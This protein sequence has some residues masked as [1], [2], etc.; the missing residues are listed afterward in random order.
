MVLAAILSSITDAVISYAVGKEADQI[1][2][3]IRDILGRDPTKRAFQAALNEAFINLDKQHPQ[4]V[5]SCFDANFFAH[6]GAPI[7]AQFLTMNGHPRPDELA[8]RWA[9]ALNIRDQERRTHYISD[10]EPIAADFL[11]DMAQ[12]LKKQEALRDL[13]ESRALDQMA[14][15][16]QA[17]RQHLDAEQATF[18]TQQ[19]YLHWLIDRN[20]YLDPRGTWQTQRQVQLKLDTIYISLQAQASEAF[21]PVDHHP[22]FEEEFAVLEM[23]A[24][25]GKL[26]AEEREERYDGL[27]KRLESR[28]TKNETRE[29]LELAEVVRRSSCV[30][31]LGDPGS[32]KTTLLRY[33]ALQHALA[34]RDGRKEATQ[35][36]GQARFPLLIR[37][38]EYAE[39]GIWKQQSL[40][41]FF[42]TCYR[43]HDC[44]KRG[45]ADLLL[46]RLEQG[47][48]LVLLDGLDEIVNAD[49]RSGVVRQIEDFVRRYNHHDNRFVITSR[50]AG[51]TSA[52]LSGPF[53]HYTV[54]DMDDPQIQHFLE[55][56]CQAVEDAQTPEMSHQE[57]MRIAQRER[58][59]IMQAIKNPGVHRLAVNPLLLRILALI[60]RTGAKLP[61]KRIELYKL[62]TDTLARTWRPA[63]GVSETQLYQASELLKEEYLTRLLS[64]LAYWLHT[65]KPTGIATEREMYDVLGRAWARMNDV[66]WD[67]DNPHPHIQAEIRKF[68]AAVH[69]HTGL[70]VERAPKRYGFLHL[71]FEEYYV[72]R[73]L[74]AS[75][76]K[77]AKLIREHLHQSRWEEPILLALGFVGLDYPEEASKLVEGAILAQGEVAEEHNFTP[78]PHEDLLG[79]D[80]LFA[81]RC[82]GD[83]IPV[84]PRLMKQL[85]IRLVDDYLTATGPA[86]FSRYNDTVVEK[87]SQLIGS[88]SANIFTQYV[89]SRLQDTQMKVKS[90]GRATHMLG[91]IGATSPEVIET[92]VTVL[93]DNQVEAI[94][95]GNAAL[96]LGRVG[97][98][99]LEAVTVLVAVLQNKQIEENVRRNT[100]SALG[101][102]EM[103]YPEVITA[104]VTVLQD[105]QV[106]VSVR[107]TV[108]SA[109]GQVGM[110]LALSE[111][112]TA[113]VMVLQDT[114]VEAKVR[115]N[116]ASAL[117]RVGS[118]S[119]EALVVLVKVLQNNHMIA[120]LITMLQENPTDDYLHSNIISVLGKAGSASS[121]VITALVTTLQDTQVKA[122]VRD[123]VAFALKYVGTTSPEVITILMAMLQDTQVEANV[124]S[125]VAY[126]L[127]EMGKDSPEAI[128]VLVAMSQDTQVESHVRAHVALALRHIGTVSPKV[129][130]ALVTILQ[131]KQ[132]GANMRSSV[133]SALFQLGQIKQIFSSDIPATIFSDWFRYVKHQLV[134]RDLAHILSLSNPID[135]AILNTL[136]QDL[137]D[138]FYEVRKAC[139]QAL[140]RIGKRQSALRA[141]IETRLIEAMHDP[142][143]EVLDKVE[144]RPAYDAVYEGLWLL[145]VDSEQ[146]E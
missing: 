16:L 97:S 81:L 18:G 125:S 56:W 61:Q 121:E 118:A 25:T 26:S 14:E 51:Y 108:A 5:A 83:A 69:A 35:D 122:K 126:A 60:H 137:L 103:V 143:F 131:D 107:Y 58:D 55:R 2:D 11:H 128:A 117:Y 99:S 98:N 39:N 30:V 41:D 13:N 88:E 101:L 76:R 104:L 145:L 34:L 23:G 140:A 138:E 75:P 141:T 102:V 42:P 130:T 114:Q 90:R 1:S 67:A 17:V 47:T 86:R 33:L 46:R 21:S 29:I 85:I 53:K 48:C 77:S 57:R 119:S 64:E 24:D 93:Q 110:K 22:L 94:V 36:L 71:T 54:R 65:H 109:L 62:A 113:L 63:Q 50:I 74:V 27:Q 37:I 123:G 100:A 73:Y 7:L 59:G 139:A 87:I 144:K 146:G 49:E 20:L 3:K 80:H 89:C 132:A 4:W 92:L 44:P 66:V 72:A 45:L 105:T 6:E 112:I 52:P 82:L 111:A 91:R 31:I 142:A 12:Q 19:D 129:I 15:D 96:A 43:T 28:L 32:G 68:L 79:R 78:S 115:S 135:D 116:A 134:R 40:S 95:R 70:F 38:A 106:E 120:A 133:A 10:L 8:R 84:R 127:A 136:W 124:R 9:D